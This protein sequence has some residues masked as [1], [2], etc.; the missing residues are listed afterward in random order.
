MYLLGCCV[1]AV[2]VEG[3]AGQAYLLVVLFWE[4]SSL[5]LLDVYMLLRLFSYCNL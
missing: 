5:V 4:D 3:Q 2:I 1:P